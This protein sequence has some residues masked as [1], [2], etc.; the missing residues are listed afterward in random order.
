M[1]ER[2][3]IDGKPATVAY[4]A[5]DP[6]GGF[7]SVPKAEATLVKVIYDDGRVVFAVPEPSAEVSAEKPKDEGPP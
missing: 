4:L 5:T 2:T 7:R 6:A 3:T 1:I